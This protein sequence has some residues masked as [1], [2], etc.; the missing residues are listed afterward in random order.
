MPP[1]T[2]CARN[3]AVDEIKAKPAAGKK[4]KDQ[5]Q[6][7]ASLESELQTR[8]QQLAGLT[9]R[10]TF[11]V[12]VVNLAVFWTLTTI[13]NKMVILRLP[14]EPFGLITGLSHRGLEGEDMRDV[15]VAFVT[16]LFSMFIRPV[17]AKVMG[18]E[19]PAM[20]SPFASMFP[21]AGL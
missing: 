17:V 20:P 1:K 7:I 12:G 6:H 8:T 14:F 9:M 4:A 18:T 21:S 10:G 2:V 15:S 16:V 19:Q 13:F 5:E 3:H 11:I